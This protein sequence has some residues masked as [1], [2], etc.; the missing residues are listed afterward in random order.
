MKEKKLIEL[1]QDSASRLKRKEKNS[2]AIHSMGGYG[3]IDHN[4]ICPFRSVPFDD[5]PLCKTESLD[6]I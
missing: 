5:C 4:R 1:F 3:E 2:T 6:K